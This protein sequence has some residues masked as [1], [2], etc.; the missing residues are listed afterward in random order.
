M[1]DDTAPIKCNGDGLITVAGMYIDLRAPHPRLT[2][3]KA[4]VMAAPKYV[5]RRIVKAHSDWL[6]EVERDAH[7]RLRRGRDAH[8]HLRQQLRTAR[9]QRPHC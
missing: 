8:D 4:V 9:N 3:P 7:G 1:P 5:A 6:D 2:L